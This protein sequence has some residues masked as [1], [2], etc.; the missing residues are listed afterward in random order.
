M[1]LFLRLSDW[2]GQ[3]SSCPTGL[4][5]K[6][7]LGSVLCSTGTEIPKAVHCQRLALVAFCDWHSQMAELLFQGGFS[8]IASVEGRPE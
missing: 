1:Q 4:G 6:K 8:L 2:S 3:G 5:Q 7:A